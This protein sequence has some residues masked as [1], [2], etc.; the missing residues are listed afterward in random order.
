MMTYTHGLNPEYNPANVRP[1]G[2]SSQ[3]DDEEDYF[4]R[5]EEIID[6]EEELDNE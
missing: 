4:A 1:R 2:Y 5:E 6:D 3:N